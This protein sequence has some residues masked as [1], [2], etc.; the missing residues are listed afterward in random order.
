MAKITIPISEISHNNLREISYLTRKS[1]NKI[2]NEVLE[3]YLPDYLKRVKE[4]KK[5]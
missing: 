5:D 3:T 2:V 4:E 1:I